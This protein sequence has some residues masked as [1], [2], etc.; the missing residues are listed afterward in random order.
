MIPIIE[1]PIKDPN[2]Y[3]FT[4]LSELQNGQRSDIDSTFSFLKKDCPQHLQCAILNP[5][6][7]WYKILVIN[8]FGRFSVIE[9]K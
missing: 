7:V 9:D 8:F 5:S 2:D 4:I 1:N 3:L 6:F